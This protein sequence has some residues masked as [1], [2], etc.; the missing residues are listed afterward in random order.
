MA[1]NKELEDLFIQ[2]FSLPSV[3]QRF[4]FQF[5]API[6]TSPTDLED[7]STCDAIYRKVRPCVMP[8]NAMLKA[9]QC[10]QNIHPSMWQGRCEGFGS[11][12]SDFFL[13][14]DLFVTPSPAECVCALKDGR[15][16][17]R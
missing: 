10:V 15:L 17:R 8:R 13:E 4:Y 7:R 12:A 9:W 14:M 5:R 3:P 6:T 16:D 11:N 2:P 1:E